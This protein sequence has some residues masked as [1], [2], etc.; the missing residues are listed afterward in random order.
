[1]TRVLGSSRHIG[2]GDPV[3]KTKISRELWKM[4]EGL[5][6]VKGAAKGSKAEVEQAINE[7]DGIIW[8]RI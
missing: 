3:A 8:S 5:R 6:P 4:G 2:L 7:E 1:M